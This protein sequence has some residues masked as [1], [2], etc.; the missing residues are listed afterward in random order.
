[1]SST[2]KISDPTLDV[3]RAVK[4]VWDAKG[5][6]RLFGATPSI[7]KLFA[8]E[9]DKGVAF[10]FVVFNIVTTGIKKRTSNSSYHQTVFQLAVY[11][12]TIENVANFGAMIDQYYNDAELDLT[13]T[14]EGEIFYSRRTGF[15]PE[16]EDDE[17]WRCL[18]TYDVLS[19]SD[20]NLIHRERN[21]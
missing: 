5:L 17:A 16:K 7:R 13:P 6:D 3:I 12:S 9:A 10:P 1:V 20:R 14:I 2:P 8:G 18:I 19:S 21:Q 11:D 15:R 4:R